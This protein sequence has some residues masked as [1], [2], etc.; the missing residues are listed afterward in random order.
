MMVCVCV[1]EREREREN[2][3]NVNHKEAVSKVSDRIQVG[4]H[5]S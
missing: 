1:C 4:R 2:N 3:S 5:T